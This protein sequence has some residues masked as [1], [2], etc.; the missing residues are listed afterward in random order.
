MLACCDLMTDCVVCSVI[1]ES[2]YWFI[3]PLTTVHLNINDCCFILLGD[4]NIY[5]MSLTHFCLAD[6]S[7]GTYIIYN[8][9]RM[10]T[11]QSITHPSMN[12][13][14]RFLLNVTF[15]FFS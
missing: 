4:S 12:H 13:A 6:I 1:D 5:Y 9:T 11:F 8:H 3:D 15:I 7:R 14:I 10:P 2:V